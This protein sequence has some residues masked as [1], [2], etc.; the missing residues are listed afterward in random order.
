MALAK[1]LVGAFPAGQAVAIGGQYAAVV[2]TGS[3]QATCTLIGAGMNMVTAADGTKGVTL[4]AGMPGDE[5][6]IF[7]NS[8]ST[9]PVYPPVGAAIAVPGTGVGTANSAFSQLTY[10]TTIYKCFTSTEWVPMVTA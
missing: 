2:A 5:V 3:S 7:N 4:P 6:W 1:E 8:G 9:C 10:K